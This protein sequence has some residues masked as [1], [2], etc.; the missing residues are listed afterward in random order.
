[1]L[2]SEMGFLTLEPLL[3]APQNIFRSTPVSDPSQGVP[4]IASG[5]KAHILSP[6]QCHR[7]HF[8]PKQVFGEGLRSLDPRAA[9]S[10]GPTGGPRWVPR[11]TWWLRWQGWPVP[12]EC[13]HDA[14]VS[15]E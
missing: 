14:L 10:E 2:P 12:G 13:F 15:P 3:E 9:C 7:P 5:M 8:C 11:V 1:M 6:S 4:G